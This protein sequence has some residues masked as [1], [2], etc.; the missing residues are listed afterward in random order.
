MDLTSVAD[1]KRT[2]EQLM[3]DFRKLLEYDH[4]RD[5]SAAH[6][7]MQTDWE[8]LTTINKQASTT[9]GMRGNPPLFQLF[10]VKIVVF[11]V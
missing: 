8:I 7:D 9:R 4:A 5:K 1:F 2:F 3:A 10:Q 11:F 6:P